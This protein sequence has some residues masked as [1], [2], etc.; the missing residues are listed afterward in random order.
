MARITN[1]RSLLRFAAAHSGGFRRRAAAARVLPSAPWLPAGCLHRC[2]GRWLGLPVVF[3]VFQ[4]GRL[5]DPWYLP[6]LQPPWFCGRR[7]G[8]LRRSRP[9][10]IWPFFG[11]VCIFSGPGGRA[12][13]ACG[14]T[15][16]GGKPERPPRS[17]SRKD[18]HNIELSVLTFY[19]IHRSRPCERID[20]NRKPQMRG[21]MNMS[22]STNVSRSTHMGASTNVS[23]STHMGAS[24]IA[25]G[26]RI[27]V[28]QRM[29]AVDE[30]RCVNGYEWI[31]GWK[32]GW[33]AGRT[34]AS[35]QHC[36]PTPQ[37]QRSHISRQLNG[38]ATAM[39]PAACAGEIEVGP[40]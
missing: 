10:P 18:A 7:P 5:R 4:G 27:W 3:A 34:A 19:Q 25:S 31:D 22:A 28:R 35:R 6:H 21:L 40:R 1:R 24:T 33:R 20:P 17:A 13:P 15:P 9:L 12:G 26:R 37:L 2:C 30:N 32:T 11:S 14:K 36:S 29:Q 39:P 23:R 38:V 16:V 8:R